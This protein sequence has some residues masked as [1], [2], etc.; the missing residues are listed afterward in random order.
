MAALPNPVIVVPGAIA[1]YLRDLYPIPPDLIWSVL[2][3]NYERATLHPDDVLESVPL[4]QR[5]ME[6]IEPARIVPDEV[7]EIVYKELIEELRHNLT[8]KADEPVPVYAFGYDWRQ[9]LEVVQA[10]LAAFIKEVG[11]RTALMRHYFKAGY[12]DDPRVN[13]IGHSMGGLIIAGCLAKFGAELKVGK[14]ATLGSPFQGSFEVVVKAATGDANLGTS[15][16]SS[17]EREAARLTPALYYLAP[18]FGAVDIDPGLPQTNLF[19]LALWQPSI[20]DTIAEYIRLHGRA[21]LA[22]GPRREMARSILDRML[23]AARDHRHILDTL[24][25]AAAGLATTDWLC[26]IGVDAETR[27]RVQVSKNGQN[28]EFTFRL[29]DRA[30]HW[31]DAAANIRRQTGDGTVP[32]EGAIPKFLPYESLV[33]VS[34]ADFDP[35]AEIGDRLELKVVGFHG[36]LPNMNMLQRLI[37]RFFT[38]GRPDSRNTTWGRPAPGVA[39]WAPPLPLTP[40]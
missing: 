13:L 40:V 30:N 31:G 3:N 34:P 20:V 27:I 29:A 23:T 11:R 6:A 38:G 15:V 17:R 4:K 25:L 2:T 14:V 1:T 22:A 5:T 9:P 7:Y 26:V 28:P 32:F 18:S 8:A 37:V 33:C 10:E 36:M 21:A 24:D 12:A 35:W 16:P 19:D 39:A